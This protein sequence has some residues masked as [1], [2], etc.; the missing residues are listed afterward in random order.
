MSHY[1]IVLTYPIRSA[2]VYHD[3]LERIVTI[4]IK[5]LCRVGPHGVVVAC[6]DSLREIRVSP[7]VDDFVASVLA[8]C[9]SAGAELLIQSV[10]FA[11]KHFHLDVDDVPVVPGIASRPE[12]AVD[13]V[14]VFKSQSAGV[15]GL[16]RL[17]RKP[18]DVSVGVGLRWPDH[19]QFVIEAVLRC[20]GDCTALPGCGH[21]QFNDLV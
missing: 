15:G 16:T 12:L 7:N 19:V 2:C 10:V 14:Q 1:Y 3:V 18:S 17:G 5:R 13:K 4:V 21:R 8:P 11:P 6:C 20:A 9:P